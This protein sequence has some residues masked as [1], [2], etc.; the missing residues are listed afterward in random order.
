MLM[1]PALMYLLLSAA[2]LLLTCSTSSAKVA[3]SFTFDPEMADTGDQNKVLPFLWVQ[4]G[5]VKT[6]EA[7]KPAPGTTGGLTTAAS[8]AADASGYD[9]ELSWECLLHVS[10]F[11]TTRA[12]LPTGV[13][14][15]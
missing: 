10:T 11:A 12:A 14:P 13:E 4:K 2:V 5:E 6:R 7:P 15:G 1:R 9:M 3:E 8:A